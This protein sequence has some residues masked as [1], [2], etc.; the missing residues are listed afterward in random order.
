MIDKARKKAE[1]LGI[2]IE[3]QFMDFEMSDKRRDCGFPSEFLHVSLDGSVYMCC[4]GM[5]TFQNVKD[6]PVCDIW[7]SE[8]YLKLRQSLDTGDYPVKCLNCSIMY[9]TIENQERDIIKHLT[10]LEKIRKK[11]FLGSIKS[12]IALTRRRFG[13]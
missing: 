8:I 10:L 12:A 5:P 4:G 3:A 1:S 7:N 9:N 2:T 6:T 11:G 13:F